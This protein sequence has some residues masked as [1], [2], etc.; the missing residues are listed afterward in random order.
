MEP[1][2]ILTDYYS[3]DL[4]NYVLLGNQ[5]YTEDNRDFLPGQNLNVGALFIFSKRLVHNPKGAH[6]EYASEFNSGSNPHF[7]LIN[8]ELNLR[9]DLDGDAV[10]VKSEHNHTEEVVRL[11]KDIYDRLKKII[12]SLESEGGQLLPECPRKMGNKGEFET[13]NDWYNWVKTTH[14]LASDTLPSQ[15]RLRRG[16]DL[17]SEYHD[18]KKCAFANPAE[19]PRP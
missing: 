1:T 10:E 18:P 5:H 3:S 2:S 12:L 19:L 11:Q 7:V 15:R 6:A 14:K 16:R 13:Y 17:T 4:W 9:F 8:D